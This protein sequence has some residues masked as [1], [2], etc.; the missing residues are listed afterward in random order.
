MTEHSEDIVSTLCRGK[1]NNTYCLIEEIS[2]FPSYE[3]SC[4][5]L[6]MSAGVP[7]G[8]HILKLRTLFW[9]MPTAGVLMEE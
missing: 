6:T 4:N 8:S 7:G 9:R 2:L 5:K 3:F 1:K